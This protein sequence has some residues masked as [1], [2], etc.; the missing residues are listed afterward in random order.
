[1][2]R[3]VSAMV[4]LGGCVTP[5]S[6]VRDDLQTDLQTVVLAFVAATE[7]GQFEEVRSL[8]CASLQERYTAERL[9]FDYQADPS[10]PARVQQIKLKSSGPFVEE[11]RTAFLQW[12]PDRRLHFVREDKKWRIA[13]LEEVT[14]NTR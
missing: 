2:S 6:V 12:A 8:L 1:M 11:E 4:L 14:S 9:R 3:W 5:V 13:A 7:E 10:A